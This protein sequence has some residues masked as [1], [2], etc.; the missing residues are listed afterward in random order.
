M[1][2]PTSGIGAFGGGAADTV[3]HPVVAIAMVA[4][5]ALMLWLPRKYAV[6]PFLLA[7]FLLPAGQ[8]LHV[9]GVHLY[10]P[11]ILIAFGVA[12][13]V[14]A[15]LGSG[16]RIFTNGWN[17]LDKIFTCWALL[18]VVVT[19][20][21]YG[22][23]GAA[24][25]Q[26][27]GFIWDTLGGYYLLRY[28]IR[29][30]EDIRR[31]AKTF[32]LIVGV[33]GIALLYERFRGVNVFGYFGSI[34]LISALRDGKIRAQG[35]FAHPILAGSFAATLLPFFVWLWR[36]RRTKLLAVVGV[37]GCTAMVFSSS[38]A[39]PLSI[40]M[41]VIIGICF[42][43]QRLRM[44]TV[45]WVFLVLLVACA[46]AMKAPVWFLI[47][48]VT[49]VAGNSGW[50]R[51]NLIDVFFRH[52]GDWWLLGT[53]KQATW[54]FGNLDDLCEQ[55]ISEGE[56]GGLAT[57]LCFILLITQSFRRLG[58][59]RKRISQDRKQEWLLWLIGVALFAHCVGYFGISY[60][61]QTKYS[62]FALLAIITVVTTRTAH[63]KNILPSETNQEPLEPIL[64]ELLPTGSRW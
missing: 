64:S 10:V 19:T 33:L 15:K 63:R 54:G 31:V 2:M 59:A 42:W 32:A 57:L 45:R 28:L 24:L 20:L 35:P 27:A 16:N 43:P 4:A 39:T 38:S 25:I 34:P 14:R 50:H 5:I 1:Q 11:R 13:L 36:S 51:A 8:E 22:G 12:R 7:L 6:V 23:N 41:A 52:F 56:T 18:H 53:D 55:W 49:L 17:D 46:L 58:K 26:R 21:Y 47:A 9:G 48:R 37:A 61:D 44:R 60:F 3:M 62:W 29:D 30:T 40:Y